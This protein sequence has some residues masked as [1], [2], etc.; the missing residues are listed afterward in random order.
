MSEIILRSGGELWE[1][2][3]VY[4]KKTHK[5]SYIEERVS[6]LPNSIIHKVCE[7][8]SVTLKDIFLFLRKNI[9]YFDLILGNW[10]KEI[11]EEGL[12]TDGP[13]KDKDIQ[14]LEI[15]K[16]IFITDESTEGL[17]RADFHGIGY[18]NE[19]GETIPW[20]LMLSSSQ[21]LINIPT[22]LCTTVKIYRDDEE[23]INGSQPVLILKNVSFTLF[24]ILY[25]II[26]EL[27]F[28]G[29]PK[30]RKQAVKEIDSRVDSIKE[31]NEVSPH[32]D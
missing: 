20:G 13:E 23:Q 21:N 22:Q 32:L 9:D 10:C 30:M 29:S 5:G 3:W 31:K 7:L 17:S 11:V 14:Y 6:T 1:R 26:W 24:E 15:Y 12:S 16:Q 8:E 18:E 2:K 19:E 27:S 25:A 28:L 4:N